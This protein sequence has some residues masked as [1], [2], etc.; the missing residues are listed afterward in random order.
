[1]LTS[2]V[3]VQ[4]LSSHPLD[5]GD[6]SRMFLGALLQAVLVLVRLLLVIRTWSWGMALAQCSTKQRHVNINVSLEC[7]NVGEESMPHFD[8]S[9]H[10]N[11]SH[12]HISI[13]FYLWGDDYTT[14][15]PSFRGIIHGRPCPLA[16]GRGCT[17]YGFFLS[18]EGK[19][20]AM[21]RIC[22]VP[23]VCSPYSNCELAMLSRTQMATVK[24]GLGVIPHGRLSLPEPVFFSYMPWKEIG[25]HCPHV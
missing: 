16:G 5:L 1:M 9:G 6:V 19:K 25:Y 18:V 24:E 10:L 11:K 21:D 15:H 14:H 2:R 4:H 13:I 17:W 12:T 7:A 23:C 20:A 22:H 8:I 3:S